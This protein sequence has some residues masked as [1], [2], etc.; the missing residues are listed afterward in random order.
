MAIALGLGIGIGFAPAQGG[1]GDGPSYD[2]D[3][4]AWFDAM[5][6]QPDATRKGL[7]NDLIV[8]LKASTWAY[9]DLI[10]VMALGTAQAANL[11][12]KSPS[13]FTL[14]PVNSPVFTADKGYQGDG[15]SSYIGTGYLF[16]GAG[17]LFTQD[18]AGF[19]VYVNG[20]PAEAQNTDV[21]IGMDTT[22]GTLS[23]LR[24]RDGT[25]GMGARVNATTNDNSASVGGT[26]F[27]YE[28]VSRINSTQMQFYG[29]D[30]NPLGG[31]LTRTS[32]AMQ[33]KEIQLLRLGTGYSRDRLAFV[34]VGGA[35]PDAAVL[36]ERNAILTYLT[37][38][39][40]N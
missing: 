19:A 15:S 7:L 36:A 34:A 10:Y 8:A 14:S 5:T 22:S 32:A 2:A 13:T 37:A 1:G 29:H 31:P 39:G 6:V 21:A 23:F 20:A 12:A 28:A 17:Q 25:G 30:G 11:N 38:I 33:A 35:P 18:N 40:A 3:A 9:R 26:R 4:Q 27:G 24:P 16:T